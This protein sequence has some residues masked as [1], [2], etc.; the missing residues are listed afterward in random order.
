MLLLEFD[1]LEN[2]WSFHFL[3]STGV[4]TNFENSIC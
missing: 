1:D 3:E 2:Y 4:I